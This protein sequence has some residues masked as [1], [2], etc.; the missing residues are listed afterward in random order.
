M[1]TF[2][3]PVLLLPSSHGFTSLP[4]AWRLH[5]PPAAAVVISNG[6]NNKRRYR[7]FNTLPWRNLVRSALFMGDQYNEY[8]DGSFWYDM[9]KNPF[10][11][12]SESYSTPRRHRSAVDGED[13]LDAAKRWLL[14]H[15]PKLQPRHVEDYAKKLVGDGFD[16]AE[17]LREVVVDDL[18][19]MK[20]VSSCYCCCWLLFSWYLFEKSNNV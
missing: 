10:E 4:Q 16:S 18:D 11:P 5:S 9:T 6:D 8:A 3:I 17:M 7:D 19:F 12:R 20:V 1:W 15:L 13:K 2:S 14:F